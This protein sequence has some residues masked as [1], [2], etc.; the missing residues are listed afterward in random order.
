MQ[1]PNTLVLTESPFSSTNG[2]GVT[3]ATLF[4]GWPRERFLVLYRSQRFWDDS[5]AQLRD[6]QDRMVHMPLPGRPLLNPVHVRELKGVLIPYLLGRTPS[7]LGRYSRGWIDRTLS[8]WKPEVIYCWYYSPVVAD[9]GAWLSGM[10]GI[11]LVLHV[12]DDAAFGKSPPGMTRVLREAAAR[13][14]ISGEMKADFEFRFGASF[15]V[16][17]NGAAAEIFEPPTSRR[18][19]N[20]GQL[21]LRYVGSLVRAH[22]WG[23]MEDVAEAVM[24]F[25]ER[26]GRARFEI[27]GPEWTADLAHEL[28]EFPNVVY[29]GFAEKPRNYELMKTADLLVL[30]I[31]FDEEQFRW[32]RLSMPTK[33]PEYLASGTPT[34]VYGPRGCAPVEFCLEND[35]GIVHTERSVAALVRTLETLAEA[36]D[37]LREVAA[38]HREIAEIK[39]SARAM[40]ERL[41][42]ILVEAIGDTSASPNRLP[43]GTPIGA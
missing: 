17:H 8:G 39:V 32:V 21:V 4:A 36:R 9:Y 27:Y 1:Y 34:L 16:I 18:P 6:T 28:A 37:G 22:H 29:A 33:L 25:N 24:L 3:L 30:P 7:W 35:V 26:G 10:L 13:I 23:A 31:T 2:F 11:P 19:T 15:E 42:R 14:A 38:R 5:S 20:D 40:S 43:D 12:G 41:R